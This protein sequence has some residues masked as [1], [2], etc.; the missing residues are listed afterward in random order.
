MSK[1]TSNKVSR[2]G[3][4]G[5]VRW[6]WIT[7]M[8]RAAED[9]RPRNLRSW[10]C[11]SRIISTTHCATRVPEDACSHRGSRRIVAAK[12]KRR[13][14][15]SKNTERGGGG[16]RSCPLRAVAVILEPYE[17]A[18]APRAKRIIAPISDETTSSRDDAGPH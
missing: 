18:G 3:R 11:S 14:L 9:D 10:P 6:C 17:M 2:E 12:G 4:S 8:S 13:L 15:A 1:Q 7:N 5:A 16:E